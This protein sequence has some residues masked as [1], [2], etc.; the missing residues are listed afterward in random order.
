DPTV[1]SW[2]NML[3]AAYS[4]GAFYGGSWWVI[5]PPGLAILT[6]VLSFSLVGYALD[7][8]LN[9]KLRKR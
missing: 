1:I 4:F 3:E 9:P 8:V 6:M 5:L 7:D 2:G